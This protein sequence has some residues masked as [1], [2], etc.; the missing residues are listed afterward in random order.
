MET[1]SLQNSYYNTK[2]NGLALITGK[3]NN[4]IVVDIDNIEH[5][6]KFLEENDRDE[7][8]TVKAISGSGGVHLYFKG[9]R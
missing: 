1:S 4:I 3:V 2:Y 6:N 5:W 9:S 7:P 8:N